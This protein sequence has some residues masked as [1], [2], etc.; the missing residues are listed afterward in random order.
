MLGPISTVV[1]A[2][3]GTATHWTPNLSFWTERNVGDKLLA[4]EVAYEVTGNA[5]FK[6]SVQTIVNDLLWHQNGAGGQLPS[7]RIDGGLYHIGWQHDASEVSDPNVIIASSWM[8]AL[9]VDPMVRAYGVWQNSQIADFIVRMGN[10]EKAA[11]KTDADGQFGGTH[12]YPDYLMRADGTSENRSDTDVQH[13]MD[14][15]AVAAWATYFAELRGTPDASLRQL[16]KDLYATYSVGVNFWTRPGGTNFNV[17]PPRRY[18]WEYKN[19][20]GFSWALTGTDAPGQAGMLHF[21]AP[22]YSVV[23]HQGTATIA[24]TRTNGST[25]SVS[26]HY[27]TSDGTATAG[28][29]YT[30]TSGT[31]TFAD[32]ETSKTF[33]VPILDDTA[34]ENMETVILTLSNPSGG[35]ALSSPATA[36]LS[37]DSDDTT[38]QPVTLT[39]RQGV[40]DYTGTTAA[41]I[42]NQYGGNGSTNTTGDQLGVYQVTG[43]NGYTIEGLIRFS[44]L[45]ITTHATTNATVTGATLSLTVDTW[46]ANPTI[47][48]YYLLAP[49]TT[50]PG[51]DLGWLRTGA[52]HTWAIPGALGQGTDVVAGRSFV[53]PGITGTGAQTITVNLDPAVVQSWVN[54][55]DSNQGILL[56]SETPGAVVRVNVSENATATSRPRLSVSYTVSL[57]RPAGSLQFSNA[58]YTVNENHGTRTITVTRTGGSTGSVSVHYATS[59]GTATAGS[60][61]TARSGTLTFADGETRKTFT[62]PIRDDTAVEGNETINLTLSN[63]TGGAALGNQATAVLTIQDDDAAGQPGGTF[64]NATTSSGINAIITQKYREDPNWW[65][66]NYPRTVL[67]PCF[68]RVS[69]GSN[70]VFG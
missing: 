49:W 19:S 69:A 45:G 65:L 9:I 8:S 35:A 5:T 4:T 38:N 12:R 14:V 44:D 67:T 29:D 21:G 62:V 57:A 51:T 58:N 26:V 70:A 50:A 36:K 3:G 23:E 61:Y 41:D 43:T 15:G 7:N 20:P 10:F 54:N 48:G 59:D 11:S 2:Y 25:G 32:G 60:D 30:A 39:F 66:R 6:S 17:S 31:L 42:S 34:V 13:A 55:P 16:A 53:L 68:S 18:T 24:V 27:A 40:N 64:T 56:V 52:G 33:T 1:N 37:I 46:S 47:R 28:S 22:S 63:A